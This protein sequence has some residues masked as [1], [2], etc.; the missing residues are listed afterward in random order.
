MRLFLGQNLLWRVLAII[1][2]IRLIILQVRVHKVDKTIRFN[3]VRFLVLIA[4]LFASQSYASSYEAEFQN[5]SQAYQA[6]KQ[7]VTENRP[8]AEIDRAIAAYKQAK[9]AYENAINGCT[10][11]DEAAAARTNPGNSS[12]ESAEAAVSNGKSD[13]QRSLASHYAKLPAD[14]KALVEALQKAET[15]AEAEKLIRALE[16]M[17]ATNLG[18]EIKAVLQFEVATALENFEIDRKKATALFTEISTGRDGKMAQWA[19]LSLNFIK[20]KQYKVQWQAAMDKKFAEMTGSFNNYKSSSWFAFPVKAVKGVKYLAKSMSYINTQNKHEDFLLWYESAQAPFVTNVDAVFNEFQKKQTGEY[21]DDDATIRL[22]YSNYQSWYARWKIMSEARSSLDVQYFIIENDAFGI[23]LLGMLL[24]KAEEGVKVRLMVDTRG[25]NKLS[26]KLMSR[27]YLEELAKHPNVQVKTYNPISSNLL[28]AITDLRRVISSNHD[29]ILIADGRYAIVGG[30]NIADEYLVDAVDDAKAWRD[31][32]VLITS[33]NVSAQLQK[34]YEDEF[35][36]LKSFEVGRSVIGLTKY[37]SLQMQIGYEAMLAKLHGK[38]QLA[39]TKRFSSQ[40]KIVKDLNEQL[41][42]YKTMT[43]YPNFALSDNS[44][45]APVHILDSH[46][47]TGPRNDITA[48]VVK[49]IDGSRREIII[50]N[51]YVVLTPRAEAALKRAARRG[52][53]I[54]VHTNSPE[55]SDSFPTE[56][57]LYRDWRSILRDMPT[58]RIFARVKEGQLHGKNFVF[59]SRIGVVGT[60]NFDF[61]SEK[62]NSEVVAAVKSNSFATELRNEIFFDIRKAVEYHLATADKAEFGPGDVE[63]PQKMWLIKVLSKMGWLKPLF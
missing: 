36:I 21:T 13:A 5:Y 63:N 34:A 7:A 50:Q 6:Y 22:I 56:A 38:G 61:L 26:F 16:Q 9:A 45:Q 37:R 14:A 28:G 52:V 40:A 31:T 11:T 17:I 29:K 54:F 1:S 12:T 49:Y 41:S 62:V 47:L 20:G 10:G 25:S 18:A 39:A 23:A 46:S 2:M 43:G 33:E 44:H 59:D 30:R 55:T 60:Y 42:Q 53:P 48:N 32:D 3:I 27:G 15:K 35:N 4:V 58:M 51:P 19:K 24:K 57:M 8:Q